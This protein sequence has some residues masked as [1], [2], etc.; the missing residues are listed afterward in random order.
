MAIGLVLV[1]TSFPL[2][3]P[4]LTANLRLGAC[5]VRRVKMVQYK[6]LLRMHMLLKIST[7]KGTQLLFGKKSSKSPLREK[8]F[9]K[10]K[11]SAA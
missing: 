11:R 9:S 7:T 5:F 6:R 8:T 10:D 2:K 4:L 1:S 3:D